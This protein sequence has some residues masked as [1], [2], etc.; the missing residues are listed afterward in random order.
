MFQ[1]TEKEFI[2]GTVGA[3]EVRLEFSSTYWMGNRIVGAAIRPISETP[4][5]FV[6]FYLSDALKKTCAFC[7]SDTGYPSGFCSER[8]ARE[9]HDTIR[10][11]YR[12]G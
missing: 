9:Y 3:R 2:L 6:E 8:C 4:Q 12:E 10:I 5:P 11:E 7:G 1:V